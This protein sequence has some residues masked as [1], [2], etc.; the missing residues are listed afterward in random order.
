MERCVLTPSIHEW[1][2]EAVLAAEERMAHSDPLAVIHMTMVCP[3]CGHAWQS[4]F[5]AVDSVYD[6][7]AECGRTL[8]RDVHRLALAYGWSEASILAMSR[9]RRREYL[10]LLDE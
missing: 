1:P 7:I 8:L 3:D 4:P 6:R 10:E 9:A 2:D 5:N